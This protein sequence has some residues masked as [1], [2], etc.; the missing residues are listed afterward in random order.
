ML[1]V[2]TDSEVAPAAVELT[3]STTAPTA[4]AVAMTAS[5]ILPSW[6]RTSAG[7]AMAFKLIQAAQTRGNTS[8]LVAL[9]RAGA[10]LERGR[11]V[12]PATQ[13]AA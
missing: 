6:C 1:T 8:D 2:V 5:A 10:R 13:V 7:L 4:A 11:L 12:E 3:G 9:V